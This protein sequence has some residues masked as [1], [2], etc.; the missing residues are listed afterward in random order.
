M[1]VDFLLAHLNDLDDEASHSNDLCFSYA[2]LAM[3][4]DAGKF[5]IAF[6]KHMRQGETYK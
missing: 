1:T 2:V 4:D 3:I 6:G 5:N